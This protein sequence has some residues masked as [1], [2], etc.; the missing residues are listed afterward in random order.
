[1]LA[2]T[3]SGSLIRRRPQGQ[4]R[5]EE[6]GPKTRRVVREGQAAN[7]TGMAATAGGVMRSCAA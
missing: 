5:V 6:P 1:M 2:G 3:V 4:F 7:G